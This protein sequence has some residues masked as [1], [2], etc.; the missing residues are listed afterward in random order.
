MTIRNELSTVSLNSLG[1]LL[2][3]LTCATALSADSGALK[4]V[5]NIPL[6]DVEGRFDHFD[7]DLKTQRLF[8]AALGYNTLEVIDLAAGKR[9]QSISGLR[10]PQ[11]VLC[12]PDLDRLCV[13]C[14][15]EGTCR[16]FEL[17][18]L[19]PLNIITGLPDADNIRKDRAG[20][21]V[22]VGYG[23]GALATIDLKKEEKVR[24]DKLSAHPESFQVEGGF[25]RVFVNVPDAKQIQIIDR[26]RTTNGS[27][28]MEKFH[29]NFPMALDDGNNCL[30]VGC[31]KPPR[32]AVLDK[33]AGKIIA[34][35]AIS[36]DTDDLFFDARRKCIY[37]ICGEG[38]VDT[39]AQLSR[40]QYK[41]LAKTPT[42]PGARTG[43]FSPDLDTLF[44]AVPHRG[45]QQP[46]IRVFKCE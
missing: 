1:A 26:N 4:A 17:S 30:F 38:F 18:T 8:V 20:P 14:G 36:G 23:D 32:F 12:V 6:P 29:A 7:L 27:W 21:L 40:D 9:V 33:D 35:Y 13:A 42:A 46:E 24:E 22:L 41:P 31:R 37:V 28:P 34:D 44:V 10:K 2:L 5:T 3:G 15:E 45:N 39:F 11:G 19:K 16:I 43:F 25:S